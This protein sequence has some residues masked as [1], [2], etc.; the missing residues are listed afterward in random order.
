MVKTRVEVS[1]EAW[2]IV[3][4]KADRDGITTSEALEQILRDYITLK[5]EL[6]EWLQSFS[7]KPEGR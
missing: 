7:E 5:P 2:R 3:R 1:D 4:M 6:K